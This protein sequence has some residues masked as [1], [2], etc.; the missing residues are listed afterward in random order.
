MRRLLF[1]HGVAQ[2]GR[3]PADIRNEWVDALAAGC[4][5]A[6]LSWDPTIAIDLP[7]YGDRLD[8]AISHAN[9]SPD[10]D[11]HTA[12]YEAFASDL[13]VEMH[14]N[15]PV[16]N[17]AVAAAELS[18]IHELEKLALNSRALRVIAEAIDRRSGAESFLVA[19]LMKEAHFYMQVPAA[20][21]Q[22]D[23]I[24]DAAIT[25]EETVVVAHSLGT[26]V[27]YRALLRHPNAKIAQHVTM[28][29]P[30]AS[31]SFRS[32]LDSIENPC[33]GAWFN[34]R[35]PHDFVAFYPLDAKHFD[36]ASPILNKNDV[37]NPTP[38]K[39]G[40]SG[41]LSNPEVAATIMNAVR[42]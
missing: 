24:I 18:T 21:R 23:S 29:S 3:D 12:S 41:Y 39:H 25:D 11:A 19:R 1:I 26:V 8:E 32:T 5:A 6:G 9:H 10:A 4:A 7:F 15:H 37:Q 13:L 34:A 33:P 22:V 17:D 27:S 36:T 40:I 20:Q 35:D 42:A 16:L 2:G 38:N 28:G 31:S 30:L 14:A